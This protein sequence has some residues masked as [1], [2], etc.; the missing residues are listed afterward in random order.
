M[1]YVAV[2]DGK[3]FDVDGETWT[4]H[5]ENVPGASANNTDRRCFMLAFTKRGGGEARHLTLWASDAGMPEASSRRQGL[6]AA[7]QPLPTKHRWRFAA[8]GRG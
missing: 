2:F 7:F 5:V 4:A 1:D 8:V 3:E 6:P